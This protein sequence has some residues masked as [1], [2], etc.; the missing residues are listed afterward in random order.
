[1][2]ARIGLLVVLLVAAALSAHADTVIIAS[3]G[4]A[5]D[6]LEWNAIGA[7]VCIPP[8]GVWAPPPAGTCWVSYAQTG[9]GGMSP[10]P[11][12]VSFVQWFFLPY[13]TNTGSVTV[14]ADDTAGVWLNG[15]L[16]FPA[17]MT[18][19]NA[20]AAGPIG[21]TMN[22]FEGGIINL[23]GLG[24][25]WN[26]LQFDVWQTGG[27]GYGVL[28]YGQVESVVPEPAS[29]LLMGTGLLALAGVARK[30]LHR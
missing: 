20:C 19:D 12:M 8:V 13:S 4:T 5:A 28:Y 14:F 16:M 25:G 6:P 18:Q 11:G 7:N 29:L 10:G 17:N 23:A 21:C 24:A 30:R 27:D 1:M 2:K 9:A 15:V 26:V 3:Q 22:P